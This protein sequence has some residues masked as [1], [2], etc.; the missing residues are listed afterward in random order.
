MGCIS[1]KEKDNDQNEIIANLTYKREADT[2]NEED[3]TITK[4][5]DI[6]IK[7]GDFIGERK[8][9]ITDN[10]EFLKILGEG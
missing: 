6:H 8:G 5:A 7:I 9:L 2:K 10:Y 4:E 3:N 1:N